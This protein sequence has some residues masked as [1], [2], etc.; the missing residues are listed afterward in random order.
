MTNDVMRETTHGGKKAKVQR[1]KAKVKNCTP[2][3]RLPFY[4]CLLPSRGRGDHA[5]CALTQTA[6]MSPNVPKCA[7][8]CPRTSKLQ[9]EPTVDKGSGFRRKS[10]IKVVT[11]HCPLPPPTGQRRGA[12]IGCFPYAEDHR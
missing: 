5:Q 11:D 4:F 10:P 2:S 7:R 9:N 12:N 1:Q 6:K 8:M 3:S